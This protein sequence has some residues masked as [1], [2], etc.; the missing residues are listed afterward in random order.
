M[1]DTSDTD[2][3]IQG[4]HQRVSSM[5]LLE[6][7]G[8][9]DDNERHGDKGPETPQ[10]IS[11][12]SVSPTPN[13]EYRSY[14]PNYEEEL[15]R[16]RKTSRGM[17][18]ENL[19]KDERGD[20]G[21][22]AVEPCNLNKQTDSNIGNSS[23]TENNS[24]SHMSSSS[25]PK[26]ILPP[27]IQ[28]HIPDMKRTLSIENQ[29]NIEPLNAKQ[30]TSSD[31]T[32]FALNSNETDP[33][34]TPKKLLRFFKSRKQIMIAFLNSLNIDSRQDDGSAAEDVD[35]NME[36]FLRVPFRIE[37]LMSFGILICADSFLHILTV[38]PLKFIWS[39]LC[40]L[41]SIINP[42]KGIGWCRFH[43]R[44][45]YQFVRVFVIYAVYKY[46]LSPIS[47]GKLVRDD[48]M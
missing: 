6:S 44:H 47:I 37:E 14:T 12:R 45:L 25:T 10:K 43:R 32:R 11:G 2:T 1:A 9:L 22:N 19:N 36:E 8:D 16:L 28:T 30:K 41:C 20:E 24:S 48:E 46:C 26:T 18:L 23:C 38:T 42:G 33:T 29:C 31:E 27:T 3:H 13:L 4:S 15:L 40:L 35:K 17:S 7:I 34:T 21:N 39:C 5:I